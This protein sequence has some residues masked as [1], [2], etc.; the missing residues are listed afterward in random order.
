MD[1]TGRGVKIGGYYREGRKDWWILQGG[2]QCLGNVWRRQFDNNRFVRGRLSWCLIRLLISKPSNIVIS[3][4]SNY[5][6][7]PVQ[8]ATLAVL[9]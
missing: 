3:K 1:T 5:P 6:G 9:S 7:L 4:S 8:R 2:E